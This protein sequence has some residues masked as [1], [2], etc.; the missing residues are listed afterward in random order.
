MGFGDQLIATGLA[1]GLAAQGKRAAFGDGHRIIWDG[2]S[3]EVFLGNPNIA[4]LGNEGGKNLVWIKFY[5][6]YRGYNRATPERWVWNMDWRC[7]PGEMFFTEKE[8]TEGVAEGAGYILVEP[9]IEN[10]KTGIVSNKDWGFEKYQDVV[11]QLLEDGH[12]VVQFSYDRGRRLEGVRQ[13]KTRTF[14]HAL[15]VMS[16]ARMYLGAEGGLH[17]GAAA[18]GL[19]AVVLFGGW[20]PPQVTGYSTHINLSSGDWACGTL[21]P[22]A[23]CRKAMDEISVDLVYQ[24]TRK[25]LGATSSARSRVS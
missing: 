5:K 1:R 2:R 14:R 9:N 6:G 18:L 16:H 7:T 23:H 19:P 22:C 25:C 21:S 13:V 11:K 4:S 15:A 17:H 20:I 12:E 3:R 10:W 8:K 24:S